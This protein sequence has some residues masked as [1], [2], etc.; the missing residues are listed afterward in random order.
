MQNVFIY[1]TFVI[2][3]DQVIILYILFL[4]KYL[5]NLYSYSYSYSV[6]K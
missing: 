1:K 5:E 3:Y 6:Q 4:L 2:T